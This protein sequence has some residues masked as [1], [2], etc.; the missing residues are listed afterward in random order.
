[1]ARSVEP[2][3]R[4]TLALRRTTSEY[5]AAAEEQAARVREEIEAALIVA[6]DTRE[7]IERRIADELHAPPGSFRA[8]TQ[9]KQPARVAVRK[10]RSKAKKN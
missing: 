7:A 2:A 1:M 5:R 8:K 10:T 6:R 3:D 4:G 9:R